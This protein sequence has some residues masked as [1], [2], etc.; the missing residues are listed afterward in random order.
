[1][2]SYLL[3]KESH[4]NHKI[5]VNK[6]LTCLIRNQSA[7]RFLL[8]CGTVS[9]INLLM[10]VVIKHSTMHVT[11]KIRLKMLALKAAVSNR[12]DEVNKCSF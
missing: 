11:W 2:S 7:N 3:L 8:I 6:L 4:C 12:A 1:M 9:G 10:L 5:N